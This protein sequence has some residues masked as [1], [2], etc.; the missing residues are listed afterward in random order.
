MNN[1]W[2][3][4]TKLWCDDDTRNLKR[5]PL[6]V[7]DETDLS[8][9]FSHQLLFKWLVNL[10]SDY[11]ELLFRRNEYYFSW[12]L[13]ILHSK[14]IFTLSV[15][16]VVNSRLFCITNGA[17]NEWTHTHTTLHIISRSQIHIGLFIFSFFILFFFYFCVTIEKQKIIDNI[18]YVIL[19]RVSPRLDL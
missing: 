5:L 13:Y 9:L 12:A 2:M 15:L 11:Q 8:V 7:D 18:F 6:S 16:S 3:K 17:H 1:E 4:S 14:Q 19:V 10:N